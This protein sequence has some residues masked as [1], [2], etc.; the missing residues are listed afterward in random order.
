MKEIVGYN[1]LCG[2]LSLGKNHPLQSVDWQA[3]KPSSNGLFSACESGV[4]WPRRLRQ[5]PLQSSG[6]SAWRKVRTGHVDFHFRN[7]VIAIVTFLH[8]KK[9]LT[10]DDLV[11]K[12]IELADL[13][14][15][16]F[17]QARISVK[18]DGVDLHL[19]GCEGLIL[20]PNVQRTVLMQLLQP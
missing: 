1:A 10:R 18:M 20:R 19:H 7:L 11:M 17:E 9:D 13:V 15:Y 5:S 12:R 3:F 8:T 6:L 4:G 14:F 2:D 16:K